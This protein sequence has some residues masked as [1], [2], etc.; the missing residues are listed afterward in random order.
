VASVSRE[1]AEQF[2]E[3]LTEKEISED[4]LKRSL[5]YR[6]PTDFEWSALAGLEEEEN[7]SPAKRDLLAFGRPRVFLWGGQ[8]PPPAKSGNLADLSSDFAVNRQIE[9]YNDGFPKT[10]PVGSF[11]PND[12]GLYDLCGNVQEWVADDYS[13]NPLDGIGL[14]RGGGWASFQE[15]DLYIGARNPQPPTAVN[16]TY[17][18]RVVL[19]EQRLDEKDDEEE[20]ESDGNN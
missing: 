6:L 14:L 4:L 18:F 11:P 13:G 1:E 19:A 9:F 16:R 3:W 15:S 2:C 5:E 12:L 7:A 17:G 10:A 20:S 8:W